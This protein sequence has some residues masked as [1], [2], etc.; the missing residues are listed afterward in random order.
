MKKCCGTCNAFELISLNGRGICHAGED[1]GHIEKCK[2]KACEYYEKKP[3][4]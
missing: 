2:N 3:K 1:G 4:D